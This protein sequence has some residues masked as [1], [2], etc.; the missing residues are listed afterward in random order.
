MDPVD[1]CVCIECG[2]VVR[3]LFCVESSAIRLSR[4][5]QCLSVADKYVELDAT[6]L[7]LDIVLLRCPAYRHLLFN[8]RASSSARLLM[9]SVVCVNFLVQLTYVRRLRPAKLE[10]QCMHFLLCVLIERKSTPPHTHTHHI[11]P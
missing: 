8:T 1:P 9:L 10:D 3:Q 5:E 11:H 7:L 2:C 6:L 4:C